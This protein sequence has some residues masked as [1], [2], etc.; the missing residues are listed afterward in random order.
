MKK[1]ILHLSILLLIALIAI[2][3]KIN[4]Q[5]NWK[6][7]GNAGIDTAHNFL[8]TTDAKTLIFKTKN[9]ERMR[10]QPGGKIGMGTKTPSAKL[11]VVST[12]YVS[13]TGPGYLMLG[14]V[15]GY[16]MALDTD[17]IPQNNI[18]IRF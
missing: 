1:R 7:T 10:I 2:N 5:P 8:G 6:L 18:L 17:V 4:A 14:S 9:L 3:V 15:T 11:N 12:E 13:L 16:N